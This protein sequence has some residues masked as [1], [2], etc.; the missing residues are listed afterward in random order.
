M[1]L[2]NDVKAKT[3][4]KPLPMAPSPMTGRTLAPQSPGVSLTPTNPANDLRGQ[5]IGVGPT[6]N[7]ADLA[8]TYIQNWDAADQPYFQRDQRAATSNAAARGQLG[9][10]QLRSALGDVVQQHD[11]QRQNAQSNFLNDALRGS[12]DDAYRNVGVAQQQQQFQAGLQDQTFKQ[13]LSRYQVG[14][15]GDPAA[16]QLA[17]AG[18]YR[19]NANDASGAL[20]GLIGNTTG[21]TSA[22]NQQTA[23]E[24]LLA[25]YGIGGTTGMTPPGATPPYVSA[26][27]DTAMGY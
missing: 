13:D 11:L 3:A 14:T 25:R 7:R 2:L 24:Q 15:S 17:L 8:K 6:A 16:T 5:T 21:A 23:L 18:Q 26:V 27:P 1:A 10:G 20:S 22:Q 4:P 12:I 9:G 19:D